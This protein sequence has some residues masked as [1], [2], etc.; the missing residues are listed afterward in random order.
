MAYENIVSNLMFL[1][2][3]SDLTQAGEECLPHTASPGRRG[4]LRFLEQRAAGVRSA[5]AGH[6]SADSA[7]YTQE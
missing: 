4:T 5:L 3:Y 6:G 2:K 7:T 1:K